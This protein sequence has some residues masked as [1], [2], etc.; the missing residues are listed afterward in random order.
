[1]PSRLLEGTNTPTN[2]S[3]ASGRFLTMIEQA[4]TK[5]QKAASSSSMHSERLK[6]SKQLIY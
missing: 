4:K 3:A 6:A 2:R 5:E 1:M